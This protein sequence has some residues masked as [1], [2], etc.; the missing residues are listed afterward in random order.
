MSA[1][2]N[3]YTT[4]ITAVVLRLADQ[5]NT[6][7]KCLPDD[8]TGA[9]K[10]CFLKIYSKFHFSHD[11]KLPRRG[12]DRLCIGSHFRR[13]YTLSSN[14]QNLQNRQSSSMACTTFAILALAQTYQVPSSTT[15]RRSS[16]TTLSSI[17][18]ALFASETNRVFK[19]V[20][21][22]TCAFVPGHI[23]SRFLFL[24]QPRRIS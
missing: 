8:F 18:S 9:S 12:H 16:H 21:G 14:S 20:V 2:K 15:T 5:L 11:Y 17:F 3:T 23:A 24:V 7:Y 10:T 6:D 19:D 22:V 13:L 4:E 1:A